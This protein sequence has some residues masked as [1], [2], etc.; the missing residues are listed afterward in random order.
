MTTLVS[1]HGLEMTYRAPVR[2]EGLRAA[3]RALVHREYRHIAAVADMSFDIAAG[4]VVGFLGPNGAG[5]TTT[6]KILSGILHPT[7]GDVRV[8]GF[9]PSRRRHE[10]LTQIA[11]VRGSQP[12]G[13]PTELTVLDSF[14]YQQLL[15]G[16]RAADYQASIAE[17][18]EMLELQPLL[19]RQV[20]ALSLGERMRAGLA[21]AL[22]YR[23]RVLFLDEPTLGLDV[24]AAI[25]LR[26]F[27]AAYAA[28]TGATVLLTSHYMADVQS[29]CRRVVLIDHGRLRYDG[30][31]DALAADLAPYKLLRIALADPVP[32]SWEDFGT[33]EESDGGSVTLRVRRDDAA[34]VTGRLLTQLPVV[35]LSVTDPPLETVLDRFYRAEAK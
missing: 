20:R 9:L 5:K 4:E 31:L 35:D 10:F 16:V 22:L 21:L 17:L 23:P 12:I 11:L 33:V 6:L 19:D 8:L 13:L 3:F 30:G 27:V 1:V 24:T 29:L 25:A 26:R 15:Y 32:V 34:A 28:R 18:T 7:S 2:P 14:R